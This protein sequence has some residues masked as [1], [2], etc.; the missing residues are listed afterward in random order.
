MR[1]P[2]VALPSRRLGL[3]LTVTLV[4]VTTIVCIINITPIS[5][6][7]S[8]AAV[9]DKLDLSRIARMQ[10][11]EEKR[12][13][14]SFSHVHIYVDDL[15]DLEVYKDLEDRLNGL[16]KDCGEVPLGKDIPTQRKLWQTRYQPDHFDK[17]TSD[18]A[19][20]NSAFVPQNR[21]LVQQLLSGFGFR[22]T[23]SRYPAASGQDGTTTRSVLVTSKD[24]SGVQYLL[25]AKDKTTKAAADSGDAKSV[26]D[27]Y[28]HFDAGEFCLVLWWIR[29][30]FAVLLF[31]IS[32][33]DLN[34]DIA[35]SAWIAFINPMRTALE[36]RSWP[37]W[38]KT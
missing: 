15:K 25:T 21:D 27:K 16:V 19:A 2:G 37:F 26:G 14:V 13:Q 9:V 31:I 33:T 18:P 32:T 17:V 10:N 20:A 22:V 6:L 5:A 35:K 23:G 3:N 11:K 38:S 1:K 30:I 4:L 12:P 34:H 29:S 7:S 28:H 24:L 36:L 8:T